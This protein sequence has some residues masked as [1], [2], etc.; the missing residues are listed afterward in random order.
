MKVSPVLDRE[1][2]AGPK[3]DLLHKISS[4][5]RAYQRW[6]DAADVTVAERLQINCT[7]LRCLDLLEQN[8][9]LSAGDLAYHMGLTT[10][11]ITLV[12]DRL[13]RAGFVQRVRDTDDR[14]KVFIKPTARAQRL[15]F[16]IY[17]PLGASYRENIQSYTVAELTLIHEFLQRTREATQ[18]F[19]ERLSDGGHV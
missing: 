4:E 9:R 17:R 5:F 14:R 3:E 8:K 10:G 11:A 1:G 18:E 7:D 15:A 19:A 12:V 16:E 2:K 13:E 6:V